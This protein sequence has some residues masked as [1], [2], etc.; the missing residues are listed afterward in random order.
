MG[1]YS[2]NYFILQNM[3]KKI[4]PVVVLKTL[5]RHLHRRF[6]QGEKTQQVGRILTVK[7]GVAFIKGYQNL[8]WRNGRIY[9]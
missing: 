3:A 5:R 7:D 6:Y 1:K 2:A 9:W 8:E 4:K